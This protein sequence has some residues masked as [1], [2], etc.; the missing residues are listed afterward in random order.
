MSNKKTINLPEIDGFE[1][2]P[3]AE[4]FIKVGDDINVD[5]VI[6]SVEAEKTAVE[7][8]SPYTGTVEEISISVG[9]LVKQDTVLI[10]VS[11]N[12]STETQQSHSVSEGGTKPS[13]PTKLNSFVTV[14]EI[15]GLEDAPITEIL[16]EVGSKVNEGDIVA[17]LETDKVTVEIPSSSSGTVAEINVKLGDIVN[18]GT[19]IL[20]LDSNDNVSL[21]EAITPLPESQTGDLE[22]EVVV[23]G[24]GPG[25]YAAA[26][27]AADLGKDVILI[28]RYKTLGGVCLN[29]GCIPS[30]S[31]LHAAKVISETKEMNSLG[32]KFSPVELNLVE[33]QNW[34]NKVI[35]QLTNGLTG[36]AKKRKVKV[37]YGTGTFTSPSQIK[38]EEVNGNVRNIKYDNAVIAA[39]S[40]PVKIPNFPHDDPRVMT[41][42]SALNVN[43]VPKRMLIIGGGIIGLEMATV[44]HEI[45][46]KITI[47]EFMDSLIPG[48]DQDIVKPFKDR[49][50]KKYEDILLKTKVTSMN[51]ESD[52]IH[53][54]FDN[55]GETV[56]D[57]F[58]KV[59][60]AVGR[61]PNGKFIDAEKAGVEVDD[62]GFIAVDEQ[63]RTNVKHIFAIGDIVGQPMLAHKASHEGKVAAEVIAGLDSKFDSSLIPSVA[64]TDPEIAWVGVSESGAKASDIKYSK[65]VFPWAAS[66]RS[67]S[68]ERSEGITKILF[69]PKTKKVIGAGIVGPCAGDLIAEATLAI[70]K[71]CTA[72]DIGQTIHPHPSL[73]ETIGLA[74]ESFEGTVI[75]VYIPPKKNTVA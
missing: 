14:P 31:L 26:F 17:N 11:L 70:R 4:I 6:V 40:E 15:D 29:V 2:G 7:I 10:T 56:S 50:E 33:L 57:I 63:M 5:D 67:L 28:E 59:L 72:E 35:S 41:S 68:L 3:I 16:A 60:V 13:S 46:A 62:R 23:L 19:L 43:E 47:V 20:T 48:A 75:D 24:S 36:L 32:L 71:G 21:S 25:G 54:T 9:D 52:G 55:E 1:E 39:G 38:V 51:A 66:G 69:D 34:K 22:T 61:R 58:D 49:I 30:K 18:S 65:G 73:S 42:T 37:I 64:Y 74:A 27:R 53:V 44:Y 12:S 45:G 8:P